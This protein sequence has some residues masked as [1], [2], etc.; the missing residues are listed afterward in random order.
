MPGLKYTLTGTSLIEA[1][2]QRK[3]FQHVLQFARELAGDQR[4][5]RR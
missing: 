5:G 1:G 3:F 4:I 2:F